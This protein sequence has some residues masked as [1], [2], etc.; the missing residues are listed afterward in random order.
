MVQAVKGGMVDMQREGI[1]QGT[2]E[3][4]RVGMGRRPRSWDESRGRRLTGPERV[5]AT[6]KDEEGQP[7]D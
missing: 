6:P 2:M 7:G 3:E 4:D 5:W 1:C